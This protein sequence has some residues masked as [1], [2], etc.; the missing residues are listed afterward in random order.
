MKTTKHTPGPWH[1]TTYAPTTLDQVT[2]YGVGA[3]NSRTTIAGPLNEADA[4]LIAAAPELLEALIDLTER[5]AS[6][7]KPAPHET[8]IPNYEPLVLRQART[9]IAK[10][11]GGAE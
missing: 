9:A 5:L 8:Y 2:Y 1:L 10:A 11:T 4:R 6:Y 7:L 3:P